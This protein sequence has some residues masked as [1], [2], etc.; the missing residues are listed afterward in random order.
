MRFLHR[1]YVEFAGVLAVLAT[2]LFFFVAT[3]RA[4][5]HITSLPRDLESAA[6][7]QR[8]YKIGEGGTGSVV[9]GTDGQL[10]QLGQL[11]AITTYAMIDGTGLGAA[12]INRLRKATT[13]TDIDEI[14]DT[15]SVLIHVICEISKHSAFGWKRATSGGLN[16]WIAYVSIERGL[17]Q[18]IKGHE[19][20]GTQR[21]RLILRARWSVIRSLALCRNF[22]P[23][24]ARPGP[25]GILGNGDDTVYDYC[26]AGA[27]PP[28][29][30]YGGDPPL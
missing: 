27:P 13:C 15:H 7:L 30:F 11:E 18:R 2:F 4:D 21:A 6:E 5:S 1:Y 17:Y 19:R 10:K 9:L 8:A 14:E 25:D 20:T 24:E 3:A 16:R 28:T 23:N 29:V 26:R 12:A 22:W